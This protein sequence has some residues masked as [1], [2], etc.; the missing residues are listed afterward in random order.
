MREVPERHNWMAPDGVHTATMDPLRRLTGAYFRNKQPTGI[1]SLWKY[2]AR[3][4]PHVKRGQVADRLAVGR[5]HPNSHHAFSGGL[6]IPVGLKQ[7]AV[8]PGDNEQEHQGESNSQRREPDHTESEGE[9][10]ADRDP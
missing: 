10:H 6:R 3:P 4:P 9:H 7:A 8:E 5:G 2:Q 1:S